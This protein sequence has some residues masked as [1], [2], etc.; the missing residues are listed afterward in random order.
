MDPDLENQYDSEE[1]LIYATRV[2]CAMAGVICAMVAAEY[3]GS[4]ID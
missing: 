4:Y 1:E 3:Y 2:V